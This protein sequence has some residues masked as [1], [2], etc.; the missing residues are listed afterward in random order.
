MS[1]FFFKHKGTNEFLGLIFACIVF[2]PL[3]MVLGI[4]VNWPMRS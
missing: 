1:K 4:W 3:E 2:I